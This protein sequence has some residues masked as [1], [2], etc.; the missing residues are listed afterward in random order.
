[1][2]REKAAARLAA[3]RK[4]LQSAGKNGISLRLRLVLFLLLF[5]AAV[6]LGVLIVLF[7]TGI[8]QSGSKENLGLLE[9]ELAH[10][11]EDVYREYGGI[12]V[13][14]VAMSETLSAALERRL[15]EHG[16]SPKR[17]QEKPELAGG[18]FK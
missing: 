2:I 11:S 17:L 14:G 5:L 9:K 10:L 3:Y 12:S 8:F 6:M 1:M 18:A 4:A 13:R 16:S 15:E 7:A